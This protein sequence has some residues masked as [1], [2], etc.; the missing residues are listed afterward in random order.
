MTV[1]G[2]VLLSSNDSSDGSNTELWEPGA[3]E[4][5][6]DIPAEERREAGGWRAAPTGPAVP[7]S[8]LCGTKGL[9]QDEGVL[10]GRAAAQK[11]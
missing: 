5:K 9:V 7:P 2:H 8:T 1:F 11:G 6:R 4:L 10:G 3:S